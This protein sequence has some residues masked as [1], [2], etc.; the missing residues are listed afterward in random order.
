MTEKNNVITIN[1]KDYL[2]EDLN[3]NQKLCIAQIRDLEPKVTSA[4]LA[5]DQFSVAREHYVQELMA[6]LEEKTEEAS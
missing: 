6:S 3:D 4:K 2:P 5:F 1:G